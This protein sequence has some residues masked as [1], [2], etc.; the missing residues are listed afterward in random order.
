MLTSIIVVYGN[1][2][3][4][5]ILALVIIHYHFHH[6]AI[7]FIIKTRFSDVLTCN[8][9][10]FIGASVT[11]IGAYAFDGA[12][13]LTTV[14]IPSGV[15]SIGYRVT[16]SHSTVRQLDTLARR[17]MVNRASTLFTGPYL[18]GLH[19]KMFLYKNSLRPIGS[20]H[21]CW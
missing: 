5:P 16:T 17:D 11:S 4:L 10:I 21:R 14:N 15:T 8:P 3:L 6:W 1:A 7:I 9:G 2:P 20:A 18:V 13:A 12:A 19:C